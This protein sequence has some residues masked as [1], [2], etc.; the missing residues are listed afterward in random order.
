MVRSEHGDPAVEV[1]SSALGGV[2]VGPGSLSCDPAGE[3]GSSALG[4]VAVGPGS[5]SCDPAGGVV[6]SAGGAG[7]AGQVVPLAAA[8]MV[9]VVAALVALVPA[10]EAL[11][12]RAAASTAA[13]AAALAGA[14][15]GEVAARRLAAANGAELVEFRQEGDQ[16]VVRVRVGAV[17][18][19]ARA[20]GRRA[21]PGELPA[22]RGDLPAAPAG[23]PAAREIRAGGVGPADHERR[24]HRSTA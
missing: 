17:E 13:D 3:V 15:E 16:V 22:A 10:V 24:P 8:L 2:A 4:G 19:G 1:G 11:A 9:L 6:G 21:V 12:N 7:D 5:L 23:S 20:R 14:A 18:A